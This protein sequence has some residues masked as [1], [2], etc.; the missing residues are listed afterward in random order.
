MDRFDK[1]IDKID[2]Y[3]V[4][5]LVFFCYIFVLFLILKLSGIL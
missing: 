3:S 4:K 1:I 5:M 2:K